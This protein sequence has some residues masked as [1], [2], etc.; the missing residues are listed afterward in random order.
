[1]CQHLF[2]RDKWNHHL[3]VLVDTDLADAR[4]GAKRWGRLQL[5]PRR[6]LPC[7]SGDNHVYKNIKPNE[8]NHQ[9]Q[10]RIDNIKH[11]VQFE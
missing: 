9:K 8:L 4:F 7:L 6:F 2:A 3:Q 5:E 1:M 11:N 10:E